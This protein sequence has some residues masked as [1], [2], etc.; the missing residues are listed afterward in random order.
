MTFGRR[1]WT[2]LCKIIRMAI[3]ILVNLVNLSV[4]SQFFDE[5]DDEDNLSDDGRGRN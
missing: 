3:I 2:I 1:T 4:T 5:N